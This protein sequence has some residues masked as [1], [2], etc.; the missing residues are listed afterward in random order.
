MANVIIFYR[1][2]KKFCHG[3]SHV[4]LGN[5]AMLTAKS[6]KDIGVPC[7]IVTADSIA[8]GVPAV[9]SPAIE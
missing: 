3:L 9:V 6:L 4:G 2:F 5:N 8:E 1:N 7:R